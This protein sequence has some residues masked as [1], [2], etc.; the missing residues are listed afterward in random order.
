MGMRHN[1][2][3]FV[4]W[5]KMGCKAKVRSLISGES[6]YGECTHLSVEG[7]ALR[8]SFVPQYRERFEVFMMPADVGAE[9][10]K[11]FVV[12]A[13]ARMCNE[14]ERGRLYEI[15]MLIVRRKE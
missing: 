9:P 1:K 7:I 6:C 10:G 5:V 14:L 12:E 3:S 15:G 8:I 4:R 2:S 13:E 11:P